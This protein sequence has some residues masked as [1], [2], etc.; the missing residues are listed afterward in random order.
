M[1]EARQQYQVGIDYR[2]VRWNGQHLC[3]LEGDSPVI[4]REKGKPIRNNGHTCN[5]FICISQFCGGYHRPQHYQETPVHK[6]YPLLV[7]TPI[8]VTTHIPHKAHIPTTEKKTRHL[9]N[10]KFV[11]AASWSSPC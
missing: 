1:Q 5:V 7:V 9:S 2:P 6:L 11:A 3:L 4:N 10:I 8:K